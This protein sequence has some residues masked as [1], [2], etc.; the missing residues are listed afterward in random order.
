[1][2]CFVK[3]ML[4]TFTGIDGCPAGWLAAELTV[5]LV[6]G[7]GGGMYPDGS[8]HS[9]GTAL[10]SV[11]VFS[12]TD[13]AELSRLCGRAD[14]VLIDIPVGLPD[15]REERKVD[16]QVRR[17]LGRRGS[18]V[19]PVPVRDAVYASSY[20]EG[21]RINFAVRGKKFSKQ[22]WNITPG[23]R[24]IDTFLREHAEFRQ[25]LRESSPEYAFQLLQG[26][27]LETAKRTKEGIRERLALCEAVV[28]GCSAVFKDA[29]AGYQRR[30]A[31]EHDIVDAMGLAVSAYVTKAGTMVKVPEQEERDPAGIPMQAVFGM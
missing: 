8:M 18:S 31:A 21:C 9:A 24:C 25:V 22:L 13:A 19:F 11:S 12:L 14:L 2:R 23:I 17:H 10:F 20:E 26:A 5:K 1:M 6:A 15:S 29:A 3:I 16:L 30:T 4:H 7:Q 28:P 27:P